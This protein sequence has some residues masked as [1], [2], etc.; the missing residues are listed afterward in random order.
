MSEELKPCPF[1]HGPA[2][3]DTRQ[4]YLN[5]SNGKMEYAI[6]IYCT[7]CGADISVCRGDVPD[8]QPEQVMELW[9]RRST[10]DDLV[11]LVARL[12]RALRKADPYHGLSERAADYLKRK[13]LC[14]LPLRDTPNVELTGAA[15]LYRAASSD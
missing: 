4:G 13:G 3:I 5:Y 2:E 12:V 1:C 8:I 10:T 6:A 7:E 9:N 11:T 15:R 14:G